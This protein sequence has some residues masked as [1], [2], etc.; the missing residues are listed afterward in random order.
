MSSASIVELIA[1]CMARQ[2]QR[3]KNEFCLPVQSFLPRPRSQ[4]HWRLR[5]RLRCM[6]PAN[7]SK[8]D[9]TQ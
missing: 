8:A 7:V 3:Q 6:C 9:M 2:V 4:A 5:L 1:P